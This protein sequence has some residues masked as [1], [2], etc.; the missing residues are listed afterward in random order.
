MNEKLKEI[1][2]ELIKPAQKKKEQETKNEEPIDYEFAVGMMEEGYE[3]DL[4]L[5][6]ANE[7]L[8]VTKPIY[9]YEPITRIMIKEGKS[10]KPFDPDPKTI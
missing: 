3:Q 7:T 8:F 2:K 1:N 6:E 9:H 4:S 10:V 5:P